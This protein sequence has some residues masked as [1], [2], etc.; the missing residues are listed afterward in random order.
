[1]RPQIRYR[2]TSL[3]V[4]NN[5]LPENELG[6]FGRDAPMI[7]TTTNIAFVASDVSPSMREEGIDQLNAARRDMAKNFHD[8]PKVATQTYIREISFSTEVHPLTKGFVRADRYWPDTLAII[9]NSTNLPAVIS[10]VCDE[11]EVLASFAAQ[12]GVDFRI[13]CAFLSDCRPFRCESQ[14]IQEVARRAQDVQAKGILEW[15]CWA[16]GDANID[17]FRAI[18]GQEPL[19]VEAVDFRAVFRLFTESLRQVTQGNLSESEEV[20]DYIRRGLKLWE[21]R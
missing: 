14:A 1:M 3:F 17:L 13:L 11:V 4:P 20:H 9:G 8:Y 16:T 15:H 18:F 6:E 19:F 12:E 2:N 5:D 7:N 21:Q 10:R